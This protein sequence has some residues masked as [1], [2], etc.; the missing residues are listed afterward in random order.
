M[1]LLETVTANGKFYYVDSRRVSREKFIETKS[2]KRL[3]CFIT[4]VS[5]HAIR[6]WCSAN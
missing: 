6:N 5:K 4:R 2:G 1:Q 3:D